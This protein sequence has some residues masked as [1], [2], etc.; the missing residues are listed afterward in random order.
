MYDHNNPTRFT[1]E[2][3]EA[4]VGKK[5][6]LPLTGHIIEAGEGDAGPFVRFQ[7]DDRF[8]FESLVLG[9]DLDALEVEI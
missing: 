3:C 5:A 1:K 4:A 8:G 9:L 6:T 7:I 2:E